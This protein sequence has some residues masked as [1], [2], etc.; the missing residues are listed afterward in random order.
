VESRY[1]PETG[2]HAPLLPILSP[3]LSLL[4]SLLLLLLLLLLSSLS[5]SLLL[6]LSLPLL[7]PVLFLLLELQLL[8]FLCRDLRPFLFDSLSFQPCRQCF[9]TFLFLIIVFAKFGQIILLILL[10]RHWQKMF[11]IFTQVPCTIKI[12]QW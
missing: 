9:K 7:L 5:S 11:T 2:H 1:H 6:S 8:V 4:P 10:L 3:L 12:L